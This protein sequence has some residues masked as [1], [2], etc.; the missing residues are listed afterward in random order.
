MDQSP[1]LVSGDEASNCILAYDLKGTKSSARLQQVLSKL[2]AAYHS[3]GHR[4]QNFYSDSDSNFLSTE[5]YLNSRGIRLHH[6]LPGRYCALVEHAGYTL[7]RCSVLLQPRTYRRY[8]RSLS[9]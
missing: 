6:S 3:Y 4:I 1:I 8:R 2:E 7:S 5:V 9:T